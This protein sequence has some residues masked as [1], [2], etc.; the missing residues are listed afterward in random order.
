MQQLVDGEISGRGDPQVGNIPCG[1][2]DIGIVSRD[3]QQAG[4]LCEPHGIEHCGDVPGPGFS[5]RQF[6]QQGH[7]FVEEFAEQ[8]L[9]GGLP[10]RLL[11][12]AVGPVLGSL[13]EGVS[14]TSPHRSPARPRPR[15]AGSLLAVQFPGGPLDF[16]AGLGL[17]RPLPHIRLVHHHHIVQ[18]LLVDARGKVGGVEIVGPDL[19]TAHVVNR[20]GDHFKKSTSASRPGCPGV[21]IVASQPSLLV[22]RIT[23]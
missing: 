11:G 8:C 19:G 7:F 13:G 21:V 22:G 4:D 10:D 2:P 3:G 17:G 18:Q 15:P 16:A 6:L 23:R 12:Q 5:D 14:S 1:P 20:Q 9:S